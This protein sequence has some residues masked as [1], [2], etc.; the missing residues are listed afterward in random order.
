MEEIRIEPVE[1]NSLG[2][3]RNLA[4]NTFVSTFAR[5]NSPDDIDQYVSKNFNLETIRSELTHPESE[6]YF[7]KI[8]HQIAGYLKINIG[9]AQNELQNENCLEIERIYALEAYHG[10]GVGQKLYDKAIEIARK[11][12]CEFVW[13]GVWEKNPRARRFYE[14]NGFVSFDQHSFLLGSDL[15]A[16]IMM[17]KELM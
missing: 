4:E 3:L 5:F 15:Q 7:A 10:K 9:Q 13:L 2:E 16:D 17:R 8:D 1:L 14:K 12:K 6:F 11:E